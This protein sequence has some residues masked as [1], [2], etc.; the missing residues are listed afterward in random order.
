MHADVLGRTAP[1]QDP[2]SHG[3]VARSRLLLSGGIGPVLERFRSSRQV[4]NDHTHPPVRRF[5]PATVGAEYS[6]S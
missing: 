3:G 5:V 1:G 6:D 2:R 4:T